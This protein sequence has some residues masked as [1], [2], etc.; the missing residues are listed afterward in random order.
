MQL[1]YLFHE[2]NSVYKVQVH[3]ENIKRI[4]FHLDDAAIL[5]LPD[6]EVKSLDGM[7]SESLCLTVISLFGSLSGCQLLLEPHPFVFLS[8]QV[9]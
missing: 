2:E 3:M 7:L 9:G 8:F 4:P 6:G 5:F 1:K